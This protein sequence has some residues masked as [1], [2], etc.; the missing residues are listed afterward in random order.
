M[1]RPPFALMTA[2]LVVLLLAVGAVMAHAVIGELKKAGGKVE[3]KSGRAV[4]LLHAKLGAETSLKALTNALTTMEEQGLVEREIRGKRTYAVKLS[5]GELQR[6]D[7]DLGERFSDD[8]LLPST[9]GHAVLDP[10]PERPGVPTTEPEPSGLDYRLL[11]VPS[12]EV[13][14]T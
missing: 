6:T 1:T 10:G 7:R 9:Q 4:A 3:D 8:P 14:S 5:P 13:G 12:H 2:A 11:A